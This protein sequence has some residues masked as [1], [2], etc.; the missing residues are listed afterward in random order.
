MDGHGQELWKVL[1]IKKEK[2]CLI[3]L[4]YSQVFKIEKNYFQ[5]KSLNIFKEIRQFFY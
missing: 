5:T 2:S 4:F 3:S 1:D